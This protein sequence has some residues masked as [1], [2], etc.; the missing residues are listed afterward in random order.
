MSNYIDIVNEAP[1]K[2]YTFQI[3]TS[4]FIDENVD[5]SSEIEKVLIVKGKIYLYM[6]KVKNIIQ[7]YDCKLF[8]LI[9]VLEL[10]FVPRILDIIEKNS[11][12]LYKNNFLYYYTFNL[13][14]NQLYF[15]FLIKEIYMFKYLSI[16]KEI[17]LLMNNIKDYNNNISSWAKV[18]LAGIIILWQ[19]IKPNISFI[20][21]DTCGIWCDGYNNSSEFHYL[22][23]FNQDN[24]FIY[25]SGH[26]S[27]EEDS[28]EAYE[29]KD[30]N[31][32]IFLTK[33]FKKVYGKKFYYLD[34]FK[35]ISDLC[36]IDDCNI[37][38]YDV[39]I[40][41]IDL[42]N[43]REGSYYYINGIKFIQFIPPD[44][45]YLINL[46]NLKEKKKIKMNE[47][48]EINNIHNIGYFEANGSE[49]LFLFVERRINNVFTNQIVKG[50]IK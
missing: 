37:Y 26:H 16:K 21:N 6:G 42:N 1:A 8:K 36:F 44:I 35:K 11:L 34:E 23:G 15:I 46:S 31:I 5:F 22:S 30:F 24:N 27:S 3:S 47:K 25:L 39:T 14:E 17:L 9:S 2:N 40:N 28:Y 50:L 12:I 18:D 45:I 33:N 32:Y 48:Y 13:K 4:L 38:Y 7:V 20:I 43:W 10:P 19:K 41:K 49:Y 29:D